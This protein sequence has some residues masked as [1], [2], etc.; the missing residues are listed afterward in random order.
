VIIGVI[1]M[2]TGSTDLESIQQVYRRCWRRGLEIL[3]AR[4]GGTVPNPAII[5]LLEQ[6]KDETQKI[7]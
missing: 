1:S 6:T 2:I 3:S 5:S 4:G 7:G